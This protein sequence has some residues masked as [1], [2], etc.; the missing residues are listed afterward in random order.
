MMTNG[1]K[2][3]NYL[4]RHWEPRGKNQVLML[5]KHFELWLILALDSWFHYSKRNLALIFRIIV[6]ITNFDRHVRTPQ[7]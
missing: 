7:T 4:I 6:L 3:Q 5:L 1:E 2:Y